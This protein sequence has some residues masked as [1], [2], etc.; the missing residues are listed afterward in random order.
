MMKNETDMV[1]QITPVVHSYGPTQVKNAIYGESVGSDKVLLV[2]SLLHYLESRTVKAVVD[3]PGDVYGK[4]QYNLVV[5]NGALFRDAKITLI[6]W[7]DGNEP[8]NGS[9]GFIAH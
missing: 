1:I 5:K 7:I 2:V 9:D 6:P 3:I 4:Y 8:V